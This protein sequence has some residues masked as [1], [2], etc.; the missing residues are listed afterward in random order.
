MSS[1]LGNAP[2]R[3]SDPGPGRWVGAGLGLAVAC[4]FG[5]AGL[6]LRLPDFGR[7]LMADLAPGAIVGGAIGGWLVGP[8]AW[9]TRSLAGWIGTILLL[10]IVAVLI[11]DL[12][13]VALLAISDANPRWD[14]GTP[15]VVQ[16][17][18]GL[19]LL[20]A[21]GLLVVGWFAFPVAVIA[22]TIWAFGMSTVRRRFAA[23]IA[24]SS[25]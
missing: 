5:G 3:A 10:A 13:V 16:L 4:L 19:L 2:R 17:V 25:T 9:R 8:R 22:A 1:T 18:A 20:T 14:P 6:L 23:A 24:A 12:A 7:P 11:G 21:L 15:V